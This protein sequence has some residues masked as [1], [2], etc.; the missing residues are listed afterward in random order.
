MGKAPP[1]VFDD[2]CR[3]ARS[4]ESRSCVACPRHQP[5]ATWIP[6]D[7]AAGGLSVI[8]STSSKFGCPQRQVQRE[9]GSRIAHIA[10]DQ[11][12]DSPQPV[13]EGVAV[14]AEPMRGIG[15]RA[16]SFEIRAQRLAK[17]S[18]LIATFERP[19]RFRHELAE[20]ARVAQRIEQLERAD[21]INR[22]ERGDAM[23]EPW[24][25]LKRRDELRLSRRRRQASDS[26]SRRRDGKCCT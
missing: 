24:L 13:R 9:P 7:C 12:A 4:R 8:E 17:G 10:S 20:L 1:K 14:D 5:R 2:A 25:S 18:A 16:S 6:I 26:R 21:V 23:R 11:L 19:E 3:E 22:V 15:V